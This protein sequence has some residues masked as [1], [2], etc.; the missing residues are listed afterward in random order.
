MI[1]GTSVPGV[2]TLVT[3]NGI[4]EDVSPKCVYNK[5]YPLTGDH[6]G[7]VTESKSQVGKGIE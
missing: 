2:V 7:T 4:V 5:K 6:L 3:H 1:C